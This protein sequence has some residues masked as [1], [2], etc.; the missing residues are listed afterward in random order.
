M[1]VE[2]V[3]ARLPTNALLTTEEARWDCAEA[4]AKELELRIRIE[5]VKEMARRGEKLPEA[6]GDPEELVTTCE[7]SVRKLTAFRK[8]KLLEQLT[9][10]MAN[11]G[12]DIDDGK[13][14]RSREKKEERERRK[15]EGMCVACPEGNVKPAAPEQDNV[16]RM[17]EG[18]GGTKCKEPKTRDGAKGANRGRRNGGT[19]ERRR[20]T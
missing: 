9:I 5:M 15:A 11:V 10:T 14:S 13:T 4:A 7:E 12:V 19:R 8:E 16:C 20:R 18:T 17:C 2:D 3:W 1:T 6:V